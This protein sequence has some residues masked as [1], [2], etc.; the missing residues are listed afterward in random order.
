MWLT[1]R[2]LD[3][4]DNQLNVTYLLEYLNKLTWYVNDIEGSKGFMRDVYAFSCL[5]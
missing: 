1:L 4:E 5:D 2:V 3:N